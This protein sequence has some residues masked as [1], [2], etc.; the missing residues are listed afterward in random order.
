MKSGTVR[1]AARSGSIYAEAHCPPFLTNQRLAK[2]DALNIMDVIANVSQIKCVNLAKL[3][4]RSNVPGRTAG[5]RVDHFAWAVMC[6][7]A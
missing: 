3:S 5:R 6:V 2:M 7:N 4:S 1:S